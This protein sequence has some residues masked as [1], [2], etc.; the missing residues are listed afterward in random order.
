VQA[1]RKQ[2]SLVSQEPVSRP[3][4]PCFALLT[5][6]LTLAFQTLYAGTVR[7]NIT[8]GATV[9]EDQVTQAQLE[10]ACRDAK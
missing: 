2:I 1:Y 6:E 7:F 5:A 9:P 8:L 4:S 3:A 10:Q